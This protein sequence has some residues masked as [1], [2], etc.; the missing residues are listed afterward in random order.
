MSKEIAEIRH[1]M[2][3][4]FTAEDEDGDIPEDENIVQ[5]TFEQEV[6]LRIID[7]LIE[8]SKLL[9]NESYEILEKF[10]YSELYDFLTDD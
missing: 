7:C 10:G 3:E 6:H 9:K 4:G 5:N 2:G 1:Y 8:L